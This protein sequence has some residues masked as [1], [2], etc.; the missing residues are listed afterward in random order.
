MGLQRLLIPFVVLA[1]SVPAGAGDRAPRSLAV[2]TTQQP[3]SSVP[4]PSRANIGS[5]VARFNQA[6][7]RL[8]RLSAS[9]K[10]ARYRTQLLSFLSQARQL[11]QYAQT[12]YERALAK[13]SSDALTPCVELA[14]VA[15]AV[16]KVS[17]VFDGPANPS[18]SQLAK[19]IHTWLPRIDVTLKQ[20]RDVLQFRDRNSGRVLPGSGDLNDPKVLYSEAVDRVK[21]AH[22]QLAAGEELGAWLSVAHSAMLVGNLAVRLSPP[23]SN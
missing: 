20:D 23:L 3:R 18:H 14:M 11:E 2:G 15:D 16:S 17:V 22:T 19:D 9:S 7:T 10:H 1:L 6:Y 8:Y 5:Q 21:L 12:D 4:T 13:S